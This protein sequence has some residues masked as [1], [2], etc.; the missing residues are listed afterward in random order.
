[1]E[2]ERRAAERAAQARADEEWKKKKTA[3]D[4]QRRVSAVGPVEVIVRAHVW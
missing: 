2:A 4:K 1:M 3:A